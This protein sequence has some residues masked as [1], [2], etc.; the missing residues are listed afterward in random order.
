M[1]DTLLRLFIIQ[2]FIVKAIGAQEIS[3]RENDL[4]NQ[5]NNKISAVEDISN[6]L[7]PIAE[8]YEIPS[9][10]GLLIKGDQ[11]VMQGVT[12]I[13]K[14][15]S[16][17]QS[18]IN[19]LWHIGSCTKSLTATLCAILVEKKILKWDL[20]LIEAFPEL[21]DKMNEEFK[22]VTLSQLLTNRG[23]FPA[24]LSKD[25]ELWD[26]LWHFKGSPKNARR[27]LVEK[28]VER[29]P[30]YKPGTADVY[31]NAGFA[32][33]GHIAE[34]VTGKDYEELMKEY[35]FAP[36]SMESSGW[37]APGT[38]GD[39]NKGEAEEPWGHKADGTPV[40]PLKNTGDGKGSDNPTAVSPAGRLHCSIEDWAKYI[41]I[42]L[43]GNKNNPFR[44]YK[45]LSGETF[46]RLQTPPDNLSDYAYGWVCCHRDW[47][48]Q[49]DGRNVLTHAGSNTMWYSVTWIAPKKDFAVLVCCNLGG[50]SAE[51]GTDEASW[52]I[53][54][55]YLKN[56]K[57]ESS[58]NHQ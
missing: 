52:A 20:T 30:E 39:K 37:G 42:H 55:K 9:M 28:I 8:K 47:A 11:I 15:G 10:A 18:T 51:K 13:R 1:R 53:T 43:R 38:W 29:L 16:S 25:T 56:I 17:V 46:E 21:A 48:G 14:R 31:S 27:Y 24:D 34:T 26:K 33:A 40:A 32:T 12:G 6:L 19:D 36:L 2:V 44:E 54:E 41:S 35:V 5:E 3:Q 45:L 4:K 22:T 50:S 23:G 7:G 49:E 58:T 57:T